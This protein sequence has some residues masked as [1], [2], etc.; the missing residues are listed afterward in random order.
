MA[1]DEE[2]RQA[3]IKGRLPSGHEQYTYD[4]DVGK[5]LIELDEGSETVAA[6]QAFMNDL[7]ARAITGELDITTLEQCYA[8]LG[9]LRDRMA[10]P[11]ISG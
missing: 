9:Q 11:E 8:F 6:A 4:G 2:R 5:Q 10:V 3:E 1:N 7:A